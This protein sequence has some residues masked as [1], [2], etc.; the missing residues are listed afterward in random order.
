VGQCAPAIRKRRNRGKSLPRGVPRACAV[1]GATET[2]QVSDVA[3][4]TTFHHT[5][6]ALLIL[7]IRGH[8]HTS[9][10]AALTD[11]QRTRL[12]RLVVLMV[13]VHF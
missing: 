3:P 13:C 4:R 11:D 12:K 1:C 8:T 10:G 2:V 6:G 7:S 9:G 5:L